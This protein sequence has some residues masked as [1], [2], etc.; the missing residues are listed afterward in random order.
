MSIL[1][2][3]LILLVLIV[4]AL[5]IAALFTQKDYS[6]QREIVV[7]QPSTAVFDFIKYL[8]NQDSFSK[9]ATMDPD[10]KKEYRGIDGTPG[11]VSA[12]ESEN[13]KV[14]KG[15]QEIVTIL[16]GVR[17]DFNLRFIKPFPG[18]A[19]AYMSTE[20]ISENQ[21]KV[22]WGLES[23]MKYPMNIMLLFMNMDKMLGDDLET[24][25]QNL[26]RKLDSN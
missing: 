6:V 10:M 21:T 7:N 5:L 9:W 3:I 16:E 8:K 13:K 4:A 26:K 25:L 2:T 22:K 24:G 23:G 20:S 18:V 14:G 12:W 15:E 17:I 1:F 11:F 19:K